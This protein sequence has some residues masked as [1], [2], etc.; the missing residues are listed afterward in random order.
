M[1]SISIAALVILYNYDSSCIDNIK[2]Y[3][4]EV[5]VVYAFDN[6][7]PSKKNEENQ[8][9]LMEIEGLVYID[10]MGN[11]GL[12][13]A[14]NKIAR[15][16]LGKGIDWLITFDQDSRIQ[17]NMLN[18]MRQFIKESNNIEDIGIISPIIKERE[19]KYS[20][21]AYEYSYLD[22][23]IQ[24]GALHNLKAYFE[25]NGYDDN[26][27]IY[28]LDTDYCFRLR[29]KGYKIVRLNYAVLNHNVSD[30]K[31]IVKYIHGQKVYINKFSPM[32]Y[33]YILRNNMYCLNKYK[34]SNRVFCADLKRNTK[35]LLMTWC[36]DNHKL[37]K[38]RAIILAMVDYWFGN[39]G[40]S[41]H[42]F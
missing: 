25:I 15:L 13:F 20:Q 28:Q 19:L 21:P 8:N 29:D 18:V 22:W 32:S 38:A 23:V 5:E 42:R 1:S 40:K 9:K 14:I 24:S 6:T 11:Q 16:C 26:I 10:G 31:V 34:D 35:T 2:S 36:L 3:A 27:F 33:Y 39:M 37:S 30:E 12:S 41:R 4:D 7:E 17:S